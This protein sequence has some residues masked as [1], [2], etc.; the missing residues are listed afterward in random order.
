M[1]S[2][3]SGI[4]RFIE[5]SYKDDTIEDMRPDC[6]SAKLRKHD[7]DQPSFGQAMSGEE[8]EEYWKACEAEYDMLENKMEAWEVVDRDGTMNILPGTWAPRKKR[9]PDGTVSK[10]K[11][12]FCVRGDK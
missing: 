11:S 2:R 7:P 10:F 5:V 12:R 8:N 3:A 4:K 6:L 9:R 1:K